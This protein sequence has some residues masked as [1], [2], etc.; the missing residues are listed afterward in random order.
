VKRFK[1]SEANFGSTVQIELETV[2]S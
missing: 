2:P 1:S